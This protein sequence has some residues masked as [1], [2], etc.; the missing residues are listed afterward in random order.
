MPARHNFDEI[1]TQFPRGDD[2]GRGE[3][4]GN[5][6]DVLLHGER[7]G[8][9]IKAV[10]GKEPSP[11]I[12]AATCGLDIVDASGADNHVGGLLHNVRNHSDRFGYG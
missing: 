3:G 10:A 1:R 9:R 7:H 2:A 4:S 11:G 6:D 5:H 8:P 12:E